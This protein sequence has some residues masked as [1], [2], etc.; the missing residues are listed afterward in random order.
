V[1]AGTGGYLDD[2]PIEDI[3]RFEEKFLGEVGRKHPGIYDSIRETGQLSDDTAT[4]L[5]D[6]IEQF[7]RGFEIT[8]G[9][10]LVSDEPAEPLGEESSDKLK[11]FVPTPAKPQ[12]S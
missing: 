8:G 9:G 4:A 5:K 2:V 1:W 7:R 6:A 11:R 3:S 10:M 12:T